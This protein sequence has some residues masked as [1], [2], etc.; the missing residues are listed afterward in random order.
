MRRPAISS[1]C[2]LV[3]AV[4]LMACREADKEPDGQGTEIGDEGGGWYCSDEASVITD[5]EAAIAGFSTTP[6]DALALVD[7]SF[8]GD[9]MSMSMDMLLDEVWLHDYEP[10]DVHAE[11]RASTA[12]PECDDRVFL[13]GI[14]ELS[15]ADLYLWTEWAGLN[16]SEAGVV[17][18]QTRIMVYENFQS[19]IDDDESGSDEGSWTDTSL[20][21]LDIAPTTFDY[22]DMEQVELVVTGTPTASGWE[23]EGRLIGTTVP[24]GEDANIL[25]LEEVIFTRLVEA[26]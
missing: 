3:C 2:V 4:L 14:L 11:I 1:V 9:G 8:S 13:R 12:E 17:E 25:T 5:P 19:D 7:G 21:E 18:L 20:V 6:A 15:A 23:L 16:L 24:Q 10:E 26:D 22:A